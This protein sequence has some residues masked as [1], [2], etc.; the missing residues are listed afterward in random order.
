MENEL[1]CVPEPEMPDAEM[2]RKWLTICSRDGSLEVCGQCPYYK[3]GGS[4][5]QSCG[6]LLADAARIIKFLM[7]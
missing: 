3:E 1:V 5:E 2:V 7:G 6:K 4:Y